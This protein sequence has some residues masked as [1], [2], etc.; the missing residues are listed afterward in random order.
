[1]AIPDTLQSW[2]EYLADEPVEPPRLTPTEF[3]SLSPRDKAQYDDDRVAFLDGNIV[4]S[5]PDTDS[6][7]LNAR[8]L[9]GSL[10]SK[11]FTARPGLAISGPSTLGKSTAT[12]WVAK[13]HE[14]RQRERT[15]RGDDLGFAPVVYI[16]TPAGTTPKGMMAAFCNWLGL[17]MHRTS[18]AQDLT[19]QVITVLREL[20]TSMVLV[21][22]IHNLK[23][24]SSTGADAASALKG[25]AERLDAVFVYVGIDLPRS[26]LFTGSIGQQ[27][28]GRVT[29]YEMQSFGRSTQRQRDDWTDLV[30]AVEELIPLTRHQTGTLESVSDYLYD[31]TGGSIGSL[32]LLVSKAAQ[33]AMADGS[34]RIDRNTLD[35]VKIDMN[36]EGNLVAS[37]VPTRRAGR[38]RLKRAQ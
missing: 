11:K 20:H 4:L 23:T 37:V 1:M 14:Q 13:K 15:G 16:P 3:A 21:D 9:V 22:E 33:L 6:I 8:L 19:E 5:T 28:A 7:D 30:G 38:Q 32:R 25:F 29:M 17:P 35:R 10:A 31:R 34:E 12:M 27:L 24:R 2:R 36:A 18:T 26:D